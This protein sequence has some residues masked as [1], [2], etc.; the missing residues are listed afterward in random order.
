V[1]GAG[2]AIGGAIARAFAPSRA[3][4]FLAGHTKTTLDKVAQDV[5]SNDGVA[6]IAVVDAL[7]E[8]AVDSC[9]AIID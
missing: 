7:D 3:K 5:R 8:K 2:G 4:V 6:E 1:Y 9:G